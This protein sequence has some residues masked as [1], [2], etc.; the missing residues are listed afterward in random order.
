MTF[1]DYLNKVV[2]NKTFVVCPIRV[3]EMEEGWSH[4]M[5]LIVGLPLL[6]ERKNSKRVTI[7]TNKDQVFQ[8]GY[9]YIEFYKEG[10]E[11]VYIKETKLLVDKNVS[12]YTLETK[13]LH[14]DLAILYNLL[15]DNISDNNFQVTTELLKNIQKKCPRIIGVM[16]SNNILNRAKK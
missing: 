1:E 14:S 9:K 6:V 4:E 13:T 3:P 8:F 15:G 12:M 2:V 7:R 11:E 10:K 5:D 16:M